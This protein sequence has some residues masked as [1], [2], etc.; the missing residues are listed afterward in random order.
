MFGMLK[1]IIKFFIILGFSFG[2]LF[3][4]IVFV[5]FL[6]KALIMII[7]KFFKEYSEK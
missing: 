6:L 2:S 5:C 4:L 1:E 3:L 7:D